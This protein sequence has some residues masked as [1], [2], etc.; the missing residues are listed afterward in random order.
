[1][2]S[3]LA[4]VL[5]VCTVA[6]ALP[7]TGDG[8]AVPVGVHPYYAP[9]GWEWRTVDG[10]LWLYHGPTIRGAW[11]PKSSTW[12][13][14]NAATDCWGKACSPPWEARPAKSEIPNFGIDVDKMRA[15]QPAATDAK[16]IVSAGGKSAT[17]DR[18]TVLRILGGEIPDD[19]NKLRLT[20]IGSD[21]DRKAVIGDLAGNP[22]LAPYKDRMLVQA[23]A[24]DNWAV[25]DAGFHLAGKPTIYL[26]AADGKVLHRQDDYA[27]GADGLA[28]AIRKADPGYDPKKDPDSRKASVLPADIAPLVPWI[29][30]GGAL[31]SG[32]WW[33]ASTGKLKVPQ[34]GQRG[35]APKARPM[36]AQPRP[37]QAQA[38]TTVPA[39]TDPFL[40]AVRA[41]KEDA[42]AFELERQRREAE[43]IERTNGL[44]EMLG[45]P[46]VEAKPAAVVATEP[47]KP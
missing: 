15:V 39:V 11:N 10:W 45:F 1:M 34:L 31:L 17:T 2:R 4:L 33:L 24:P 28:K 9:A 20:V 40:A 47:P 30:G 27:D 25:K 14:Y 12:M 21:A 13:P 5:I 3:L 19:A 37:T 44:R 46:P 6:P 18:D 26:Q 41:H 7:Q 43:R 16:Y 8:C 32:A 36:L 29:L 22:L 35:A 38:E 23:Y 42:A